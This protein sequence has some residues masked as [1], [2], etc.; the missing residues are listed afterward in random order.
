MTITPGELLQTSIAQLRTLIAFLSEQLHESG[1]GDSAQSSALEVRACKDMLVSL[2]VLLQASP[3]PVSG[4]EPSS[5]AVRPEPIFCGAER[6]FSDGPRLRA[7]PAIVA[8][9]PRLQSTEYSMPTARIQTCAGVPARLH[10]TGGAVDIVAAASARSQR[11]KRATLG[12]V[13]D[14][15]KATT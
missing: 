1:G 3:S 12:S 2:T 10:R 7:A 14:S 4:G 15:G 8:P 11:Q 9:C 5:G 6:N 13:A